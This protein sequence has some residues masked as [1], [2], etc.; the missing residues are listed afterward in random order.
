[1]AFEVFSP[2]RRCTET[3]RAHHRLSCAAACYDQIDQAE[4]GEIPTWKSTGKYVHVIAK[5]DR[6]GKVLNFKDKDKRQAKALGLPQQALLTQKPNVTSFLEFANMFY[7]ASRTIPISFLNLEGMFDYLARDK[8]YWA[9]KAGIGSALAHGQQVAFT[10]EMSLKALLEETG[11]LVTISKDRWQIHDLVVLHG[12][13]DQSEQQTLEQHWQAMSP[14]DRSNY[15][16]LSE[17]L[18]ATKNLYM[19]LRYIP[20]LK[21]TDLSMDTRAM[22]HA[23]DIVL[24]RAQGLAVQL[25]PIKPWKSALVTY[26]SAGHDVG[27]TVDWQ[28]VMV[29]GVVMS[30]KIPE[31]FDPY[32]LVEV[33]IHPTDYFNG[34]KQISFDSDVTASFRRSSVERYFGLEGAEVIIAGRVKAADPSALI[35]AQYVEEVNCNASYTTETRTL[36]GQAYNLIVRETGYD[37]DTR[38]T[39]ILR[40]MT[41]LSDVDCLFVTEEEKAAVQNVTLGAEVTIR[42]HVMLLNGRPVSLVGP[43]VVS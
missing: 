24:R 29:R 39:L 11:K 20:T 42:G 34:V 12:F 10:L 33:V 22:L 1:M 15:N 38:V 43:S 8:H 27:G 36:K 30:V 14:S 28:Q 40:D 31:D 35:N 2:F 6:R 9:T 3:H 25:A 13:L 41:F 23:S 4:D 16:T 17:F 18:A 21:S 37:D 26:S 5:V 19:D 32:N 7:E